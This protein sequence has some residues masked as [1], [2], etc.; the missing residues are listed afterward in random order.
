MY[1]SLYEL[2]NYIFIFYQTIDKKYFCISIKIYSN[3]IFH[4]NYYKVF[5]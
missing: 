2:K 1:Y 5:L 3:L 4:T